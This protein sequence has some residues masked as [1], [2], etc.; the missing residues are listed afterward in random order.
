MD[1]TNLAGM[2]SLVRLNDHPV[3]PGAE[4]VPDTNA[5]R[6]KGL[7]R[8]FGYHWFGGGGCLLTYSFKPE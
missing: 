3:C 7:A 2:A 4:L 8:M 6:A 1:M 5:G